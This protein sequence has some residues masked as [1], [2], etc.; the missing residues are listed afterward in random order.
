[1]DHTETRLCPVYDSIETGLRRRTMN[2]TWYTHPHTTRHTP[3]SR[4]T[5]HTHRIASRA[6]VKE[7]IECTHRAIHSFVRSFV[8]RRDGSARDVRPL[9]RARLVARD[10]RLAD[11][12]VGGEDVGTTGREMRESRARGQ[13]PP[14]AARTHT[15]RARMHTPRGHGYTW[16]RAADKGVSARKRG[17]WREEFIK[18]IV[19]PRGPTRRGEVPRRH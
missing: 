12:R 10:S 11:D 1:M 15:A 9:E 3:T 5:N 7:C 13:P 16:K 6:H 8:R 19:N 17:F 4:H 2:S 14:R 18:E